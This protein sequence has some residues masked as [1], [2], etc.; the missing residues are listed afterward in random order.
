MTNLLEVKFISPKKGKG[1]V[2]RKD[3]AKDTLVEVAHVVLIPN[4]DYDLIQDTVLYQYIYEWEN[5]E[6]NGEFK[7]AIAMSICQFFN[8]SY[9]PNLKYIYDYENNVIEYIAIKDIKKDEELTVNY[10]GIVKDKT[11]VWFEVE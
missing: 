10:N 1:I 4:K 11:P 7:C 5:P 2:A 6:T 8:H 3:I 9:K